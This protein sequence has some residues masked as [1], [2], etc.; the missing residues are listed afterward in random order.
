M[1]ASALSTSARSRRETT[2]KL[3]MSDVIARKCR[4]GRSARGLPAG[5]G[6]SRWLPQSLA[7]AA[8]ERAFARSPRLLRERHVEARDVAA[9]ELRQPL[10][11]E[12]QRRLELAGHRNAERPRHRAV[13]LARTLHERRRDAPSTVGEEHQ[14]AAPI[15]VG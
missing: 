15:L 2:S 13:V 12:R 1:P 9:R 3:G 14:R 5:C 4:G 8:D 10:D 11:E 6:L 7:P